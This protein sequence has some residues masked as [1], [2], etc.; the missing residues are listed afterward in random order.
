MRSIL[1]STRFIRRAASY[2]IVLFC[3]ANV[4]FA[5]D[6]K[7]PSA[8]RQQVK[9]VPVYVPTCSHRMLRSPLRPTLICLPCVKCLKMFPMRTFPL[10]TN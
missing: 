1:K 3:V 2:L 7:Q 6:Q 9:M 4:A 8:D 5:A 10:P